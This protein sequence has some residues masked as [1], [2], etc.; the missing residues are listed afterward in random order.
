MLIATPVVKGKFWIVE[1]DGKKVAT[2]QSS[3]AGVAYVEQEK[4]E[5]F[6]SINLLKAKH[7]ISFTKAKSSK[8]TPKINEVSS[9]PCDSTPHNALFD[10][11]KKLPVYTKSNKSKSFYCAGFYLIKFNSSFIRE[12]CPKLISLNRYE[13]RGPFHSKTE[14]DLFL[15]EL[16]K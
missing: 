9:Y 3:P 10:V 8:T 1:E 15:Q 11:T 12:F 7:N 2:I 14:A 16:N 5:K 4:R 6:V 13:F